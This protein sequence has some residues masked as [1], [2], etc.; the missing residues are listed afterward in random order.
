MSLRNLLA[1]APNLFKF[2]QRILIALK[3]VEQLPIQKSY[4]KRSTLQ[5][6]FNEPKQKSNKISLDRDHK[7]DKMSLKL[8][9]ITCCVCIVF[10]AAMF[11]LKRH[12]K[13]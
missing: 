2:D 12:R 7:S 11:I 5:N 9:L 13:H 3:K 8:I 10:F 4:Y 1:R 6:C